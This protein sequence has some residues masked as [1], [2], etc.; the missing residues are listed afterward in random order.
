MYLGATPAT[1]IARRCHQV[2][3]LLHK[4]KVD[5]AKCH[6]C[7]TKWRS[8]PPSATP[9]T[10]SGAAS[11]GN[12][13]RHQSQPASAKPATQI[14]RR[15]HQVPPLPRKVKVCVWKSC[16]WRSCVYVSCVWLSCIKLCVC[17]SCVWVSCVC[18]YEL[19]VSTLCVCMSFV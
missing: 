13:A 16:V 19:C 1:Q 9:A 6:A 17:V 18:V 7:H 4:V 8:M 2:P 12:Q 3:R 14:A 10:Q 5:A 11:P 15:C